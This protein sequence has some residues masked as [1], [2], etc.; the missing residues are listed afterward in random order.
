MLGHA[1]ELGD[2]RQVDFG[3]GRTGEFNLGLLGSLF[4]SLQCHGVLAQV[5]VVLL[6]ELVSEPGDDALVE[7]VTA[8]VGVT[9]GGLY[10]KHAVA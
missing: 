2:V 1:V 7:V 6:L 4:E 3:A 9:I 8:Q 10:L 5:H